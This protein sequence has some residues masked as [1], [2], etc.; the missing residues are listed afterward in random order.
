M[1]KWLLCTWLLVISLVRISIQQCT[2]EQ[3]ENRIV[4]DILLT[5][6]ATEMDQNFIINR[7]IY[8]CLS[9]SQTIGIYTSMSVSLLYIR[10]DTPNTLR[11]VRYDVACMNN[12]WLR[13]GQSS[14]AFIS[15]DT[16][17]DCWDCTRT[18][19]DY[20]CSC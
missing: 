17:T 2:I 16:R 8:N 14:T 7:T 11:D 5:T 3:F 19:N 10:S 6:K 15:N 12:V 9:T 1:T 18:L 4:H 20:H 13:V